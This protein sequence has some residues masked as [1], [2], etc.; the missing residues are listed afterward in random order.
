MY[1]L[2]MREG[3][4]CIAVWEYSLSPVQE[5]TIYSYPRPDTGLS[6]AKE[7]ASQLSS[8]YG[9][10][11]LVGEAA[12]LENRDYILEAE[13]REPM[14][15]HTLDRLEAALSRYPEGFFVTTAGGTASGRITL[16]ITRSIQG[17]PM[18]GRLESFSGCQFWEEENAYMAIACGSYVEEVFHREFFHVMD[19]FILSRSKAY[20]EWEKLNPKGFA[21]DYDYALNATRDGSEYLEDTTRSFIDTFSMSFPKEDR[22]RVMEYACMPGNEPYFISDTMQ[23]KLRAMCEGIREAY[24]LEAYSEPLLWEQYLEFPIY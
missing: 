13:T 9:I 12:A 2:L 10:T 22:A 21:Y 16:C 20:Y 15:L 17:S 6:S 7:K 24:D 18:S 3:R 4:T 23:K 19:N 11:I 8:T 5:D 14:L 1:L